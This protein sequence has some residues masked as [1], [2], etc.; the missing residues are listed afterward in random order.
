M[1]EFSRTVLVSQFVIIFII[2]SFIFR[3]FHTMYYR[4]RQIVI[5]LTTVC[6]FRNEMPNDEY[7]IF[8]KWIDAKKVY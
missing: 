7:T 8:L 6:S 2:P 4:R 3:S 1:N 5:P